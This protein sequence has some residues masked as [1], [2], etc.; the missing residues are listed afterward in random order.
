MWLRRAALI[1]N[2]AKFQ[3]HCIEDGK[4]TGKTDAEDPGEI[5]HWLCLALFVLI[6]RLRIFRH[7]AFEYAAAQHAED[8][9][10]I[11]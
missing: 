1:R 11:G 10:G 9:G 6:D 4:G 5:P 2:L 3:P 7:I 8:E